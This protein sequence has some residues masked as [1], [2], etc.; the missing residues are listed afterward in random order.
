VDEI[1]EAVRHLSPQELVAYR[2]WFTEFDA[3][4][5]DR[6]LEQDIAAERLETL[7]Q[8]AIEDLEQG[9]CTNL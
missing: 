2:A 4:L 5:W 7:A 9:R 6:E 3:A 1:Q 8:E